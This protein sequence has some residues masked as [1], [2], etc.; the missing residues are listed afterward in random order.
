VRKV[1]WNDEM[2]LMWM[3]LVVVPKCFTAL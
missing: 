1:S 3:K 2:K